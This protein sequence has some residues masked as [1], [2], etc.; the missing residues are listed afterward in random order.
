MC[1]FSVII[2]VYNE[3]KVIKNSVEELLESIGK[4]FPHMEYEVLLVENG[5]NDKTA[6]FVDELAVIYSKVKG[7]HS[8][9]P[10]YGAALKLGILNSKGKYIIGDEIDLGDVG[11]YEKSLNLLINEDVFMVIGSKALPGS[12]DNRPFIRQ[13]ATKTIGLLLRVILGFKGTD[14]HGLKAFHR[15]KILPVVKK[16]TVSGDLF[17][18]ELVI[19]TQRENI[20]IVEIPINLAEKRPPAINLFK[21]VPKV[22]K[23]LYTLRKVLGPR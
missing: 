20:N 4:V 12:Q 7:F 16:C 6:E 23:Q 1:I 3:E 21:R 18:S 10:N 2:P 17:A 19:R 8:D 15:E 5:S 22:F 11:F 14:T 9:E 13:I